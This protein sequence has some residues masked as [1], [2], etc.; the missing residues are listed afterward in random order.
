[1]YACAAPEPLAAADKSPARPVI[2]V[3]TCTAAP[4]R[5]LKQEIG[6]TLVAFDASPFPYRGAKPT[7]SKPFIDVAE[8]GRYGHTT[9]RGGV[10]WED[11]TYSSRNSLIYIP[12]GFAP[13][14]RALIVVYFHGNNTELMRDVDARQQVPQ[15]LAAS[16][17]DAVL[18]AP[19]FAVDAADSSAGHF[20]EPG[21]FKKYVAEGA[22]H[23]A[24]IYGD[25]CAQSAF[26]KMKIVIVAYSGGYNPAAYALHSGGANA[27]LYGVALFDA[28]YGE[29]EKFDAWINA[30]GPALFVS[31]CSAA[32]QLENVALQRAL[33]ERRQ[34]RRV[35]SKPPDRLRLP[36]GSIIFL[37]AGPDI[38]H[39]DFMTQAWTANPLT[40][41]LAG[42]EGPR[43]QQREAKK[44]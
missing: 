44:R 40:A 23:M 31:A 29:T 41:V 8:N 11:E 4:A 9:P 20:W 42:I 5:P 32:S 14:P 28:L 21:Y 24:E 10:R 35:L 43:I 13:S 6:P 22:L 2:S 17:L 27:R 39:N 30:R 7:D 38:Q 18:V 1:V 12:K 26:A 3:P 36:R 33:K 15:Q 25:R 37:A 16:G 19:Q 34:H